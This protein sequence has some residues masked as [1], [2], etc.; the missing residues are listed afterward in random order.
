MM[1]HLHN[2]LLIALLCLLPTLVWALPS[3]RKEPIN[4]EADHAQ[5][6]DKRGVTQYK[7][8][9]VLTQGTLRIEGDIITFYYDQDKQLSKAVAQ[10]KFATYKQLHKPGEEPVRATALQMEYHAKSQKIYLLG[11]GHVWQAGDEFSGNRIEYDITKNIVNANS[12]PVKVGDDTP[13][14]SGERV[15]IIIQPPGSKKQTSPSVKKPE[16][17]PKAEAVS[18][19]KEESIPEPV[20][21]DDAYPTGVT[22]TQLN[23]RTG[24]GLK[25]SKLGTFNA[26]DKLIILTEQKDWFQVRGMID[27]QAVI[28]WVYQRYV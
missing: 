6:D 9:A 23:I 1:R 13:K 2:N 12:A 18:I 10:G 19:P 22:T 24:P 7:G 8:K 3:D 20:K 17:A 25:Y 4:I 28:G 15:H 14:A 11:Q 16:P 27:D 5:L 26:G 21:Q